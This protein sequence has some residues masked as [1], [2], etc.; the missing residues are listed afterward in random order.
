MPKSVTDT[1]LL[2]RLNT[3]QPEMAKAGIRVNR[4][5]LLGDSVNAA[6][7]LSLIATALRRANLKQEYVARLADVKPSQFSG[8]MNGHGSFNVCWLSFFPP[9]FWNEFIPLLRAEKESTD[10][11]RRQMR[12]ERLIQVIEVLLSEVA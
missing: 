8:A 6:D 5:D 12:K 10:E 9:E 2:T 1:E 4:A 3:V 11:A 7:L